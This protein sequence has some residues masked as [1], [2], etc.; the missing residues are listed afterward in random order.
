MARNQPFFIHAVI[1]CFSFVNLN[2]M[3]IYGSTQWVDPS[4][5]K[6]WY[7]LEVINQW[8]WKTDPVCFQ[9]LSGHLISYCLNKN[10]AISDTQAKRERVTELTQEIK[11][12]L[13]KMGYSLK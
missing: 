3:I 2:K 9:N 10:T 1:C 6:E 12:E 8:D 13:L 5:N 7:S 4:E 11:D